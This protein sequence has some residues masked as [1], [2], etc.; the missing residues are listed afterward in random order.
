M[1]MKTDTA[2][3]EEH[4]ELRQRVHIGAEFLDENCPGWA[5]KIN[6]SEFIISECYNCILGQ[7]YQE[8]E[9]GLN[10]LKI[11]YSI[12]VAYGFSTYSQTLWEFPILQKMWVEEIKARRI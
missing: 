7:L 3:L 10:K 8:Y 12:G 4:W 11:P 9:V 5:R 6:L 2:L 1:L